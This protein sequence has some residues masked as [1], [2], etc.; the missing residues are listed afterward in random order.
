MTA[1]ATLMSPSIARRI[2]SFLDP[3]RAR[4]WL[5]HVPM[6][7]PPGVR[8]SSDLL[9]AEQMPRALTLPVRSCERKPPPA[10]EAATATA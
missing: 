2:G 4:G 9:V 7:C 10:A 3:H 6:P 5:T 8:S 1:A